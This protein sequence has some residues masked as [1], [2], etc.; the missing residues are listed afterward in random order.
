[1]IFYFIVFGHLFD[2][3]TGVG[4][5]Y[6]K[7][8]MGYSSVKFQFLQRALDPCGF[9]K[10]Q[11]R[12]ATTITCGLRKPLRVRRRSDGVLSTEAIQA[13]QSLKLAAKNPSKLDQV[14][15]SKLIRLLKDD[16]LDAF[17]ELQRQ[18]HLDLALKVFEFM[19]KEAWY[20][21]A[22]S[23]YGD[24]ML[25]FGK[26]KLIGEVEKLFSELIEEGLEP[27]TRAY[28]EL[29]GAYL[30]VDMIEKA[31]ETYELMKASGCIPDELTLTIMIRNLES[32]GRDDLA[33]IIKNDCA[34][35]LD[36]P[37]KFLKEVARKYPKRLRLNLV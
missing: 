28:T 16:L 12:Y 10:F 27:D 36:Y 34:D 32:V 7:M 6:S 19:R 3:P 30:K 14:F 26:K 23:L 33:V 31:M 15:N 22:H 11:V 20:E 18:Q 35:Y 2:L 25:M 1:M 29:I 17:V 13:V 9:D 24:L 5:F 37:K 8:S 4:M 21:P